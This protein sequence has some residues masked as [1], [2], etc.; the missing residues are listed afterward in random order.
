[1]LNQHGQIVQQGVALQPPLQHIDQQRPRDAQLPAAGEAREFPALEDGR[2]D[3][4]K[5][6]ADDQPNDAAHAAEG[7]KMTLAPAGKSRQSVTELLAAMKAKPKAEPKAKATPGRP[8]GRPPK[9]ST[10]PKTVPKAVPKKSSTSPKAVP[11]KKCVAAKSKA[12]AVKAKVKNPTYAVIDSREYIEARSGSDDGS[13][14]KS[15]V[16]AFKRYGSQKKAEDA[17]KKWCQDCAKELG[18]TFSS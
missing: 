17:A 1:M 18:L 10:S 3:D 14:G 13:R 15:K 11:K 7:G 5:P 4:N 12:P 6:G 2:A 9:S 16:F 8:R